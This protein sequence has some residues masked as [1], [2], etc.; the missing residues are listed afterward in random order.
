MKNMHGQKLATGAKGAP[1]E[2]DE[3]HP[4]LPLEPAAC[5]AAL[6]SHDQRFDGRFFV[7]VSSTGIYCRP[8]CHAK[9][10]RR[11]NCTF[12]SNAAAA[13]AAGYRPCLRCRPELAPG[14][15]PVDTRSRLTTQIATLV[16]D[17]LSPTTSI[18]R[19]AATLS[20]SERHLRRV[21]GEEFGVSPSQYL[22]TRRL[23]LA[24]N[25]LT[26]SSLPVAQVAQ[27][28]GF[29]SV[30]RFNELFQ[31]HY[32]ISPRDLRKHAHAVQ[33]ADHGETDESSLDVGATVLLGYRAPYRWELLL[34]FLALRAIPGVEAVEDGAYLRSVR[35]GEIGGWIRV[36]PDAHK[37][38]LE[39]TVSPELLP[40][41][42]RVIV[43]VRALFDLDAD[44]AAIDET[45]QRMDMHVAGTR[46][47]G[48]FDAFEMTVRAVLGQQVTVVAARTLAARIASTYGTPIDTPFSTINRLFPTAE[49]LLALPGPLA[50][51]L[52]PLGVTGARARSIAAL[53]LALREHGDLLART[54]DIPAKLE[55][56][57]ALPGFGPWTVQYVA[58]RALGWP[59]A[60]PH[61]D[62]GVKKALAPLDAKGILTLAEAWRPWRSYA[63][64]ELWNS[65]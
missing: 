42:S 36:A 3:S 54:G 26:S 22:Q 24:K 34:S 23:L 53:A 7:G 1:A 12:F 43:R 32:R 21:F 56:L 41:L 11:E 37:Q 62:F 52:G 20:I 35:L 27:A 58:M 63:T 57:L 6:E 17:E 19:L 8:V 38:A 64:I 51:H 14:L 60:F 18:P 15:A 61:T 39:L 2:R 33:E 49:E 47:P 30:R 45:L 31:K 9:L 46:L 16:E 5:Y 55:L 13:E 25:L 10:P 28:A 48:C 50:D 65:L 44:P 29:R 59:D 40:V 4:A